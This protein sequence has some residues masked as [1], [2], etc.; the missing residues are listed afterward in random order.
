MLIKDIVREIAFADPE[1]S[2]VVKN[3][4]DK[5][6]LV[7]SEDLAR[8]FI[9]EII[10]ALSVEYSFAGML[11]KGYIN[12]LGN[13]DSFRIQTYKK[14]I[15]ESAQNGPTFARI[16]AEHLDRVLLYTEENLL[17][18]FLEAV[19]IMQNKGTYTLNEPLKVINILLDQKDGL[20]CSV[21]I[22]IL[23]ILFSKDLTYSE[24]RHFAHILPKVVLS[25]PPLKRLS[26]TKQLHRIICR[27]YNLIDSY[28]DGLEKGLSILSD[29]ALKEFVSLVLIKFENNK[30]LATKF[31]AL[32]SKFGKDIFRSLQTAAVLSGIRSQ[33]SVYVKAKTGRAISICGLSQIPKIMRQEILNRYDGRSFVFSDGKSIYLP[34]EISLY[35]TFDNNH[36]LYKCLVSLESGYYEFG[37]FEFDIE[38]AFEF[39][40]S[41]KNAFTQIYKNIDHE[42]TEN[43]NC[44][45]LDK[46]FSFFPKKELASDLFNIFEHGRIRIINLEKYPGLLRSSH[47]LIY[48]ESKRL[49]INEKPEPLLFLLYIRMAL[50][51][52]AFNFFE[53]D[54]ITKNLVTKISDLFENKIKENYCVETCAV[55]VFQT[56][57]L[58][59]EA[60][61]NKSLNETIKDHKT[62]KMPFGRRLRQDLYF[63]TYEK[64]EKMGTEIKSELKK[65]KIHVFKSEIIK[66][67]IKNGGSVLNDDI[68]DIIITSR[69]FSGQ[70]QSIYVKDELDLSFTF[71]SEQGKKQDYQN[72]ADDDLL[73][74]VF[75][76]REWDANLCDYLNDHVRVLERKI[77]GIKS[78]FYI[79][80]LNDNMGTVKRIRKEFESFRPDEIKTLKRW[81]DG[82]EF[83]ICALPEYVIDK[84]AGLTPTDRIYI[85]RIKQQR[86]IAALL[87]VDL[88]RSTSTLVAEAG[89][90]VHEIIK[91][92]V[93]LFC[94]ALNTAQD[95]FA[96]AGFSGTG[97]LGVDYYNIKA[98]SENMD[99]NVINRINA[100]YPQRRTRMGAAIRH[101]VYR[102]ENT[103]SKTRLL[104]II[105]D[106]FPN[107]TDY[108][109]NYAIEDTRRAVFEAESKKICVRAITIDA[110]SDLRLDDLYGPYNH[111]IISDVRDLPDRL[112]KI[113]GTLTRQ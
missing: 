33:L 103:V 68:K 60:L 19:A 72:Y 109:Q 17:E 69:N 100:I 25:F 80:V 111:N 11:L 61:E 108:K 92:A 59:E 52:D 1:F 28:F 54:E 65:R 32:E 93:V 95:T 27:D 47:P 77:E 30:Q 88:S 90:T 42:I 22:E 86:D 62:L 105:S 9:D 96:I 98:F 13:A 50:G 36:D 97:R 10:W 56:Y 48:D 107:D 4:L 112:L 82:E 5:K 110:A 84:K 15:R 38:K 24:S 16:M 20:T 87:L 46:F 83:D 41:M 2:E 51:T 91:E 8:I 113:Y 21:Y 94:E 37:T 89:K 73:A 78:D 53:P 12:L 35:D 85:K 79:N 55:S 7:L 49:F 71:L 106:G 23:K 29:N 44:H 102:L 43:E 34:D 101:A 57:G 3:D 18:N 31:L 99:E 39:S 40:G 66:R 74:S 75:R 104:L 26:Q 63:A 64:Y 76:Y 45:D 14:R 70:G 58:I 81:I 6:E 67:L